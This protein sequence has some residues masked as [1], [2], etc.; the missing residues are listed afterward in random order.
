MHSKPNESLVDVL[1][2]AVTE[3]RQLSYAER[4]ELRLRVSDRLRE[5]IDYVQVE[6]QSK[7][8]DS[9]IEKMA[10]KLDGQRTFRDPDPPN[11]PHTLSAFEC[12]L[13]AYML[14]GNT[15]IETARI[16]GVSKAHVSKYVLTAVRT[17]GARN[18]V[19]AVARIF[20]AVTGDG[21]GK[22]TLNVD[23]AGR[24]N[25]GDKGTGSDARFAVTE[26]LE[27]AWPQADSG[28]SAWSGVFGDAS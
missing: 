20:A 26:A 8:L 12:D 4:K 1:L 13:L 9:R 28:V 25:P 11:T 18:R 5:I 19:H 22:S 15:D 3:R 23:G 10:A 27:S 24:Y 2:G 6:E 17:V 21:V 16:L 7:I 14:I